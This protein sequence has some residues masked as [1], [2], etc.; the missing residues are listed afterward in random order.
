MNGFVSELLIYLGLFGGVAAASGRG[1]AS[2]A[3]AALAA[4][5]LAM[6]GALAVACFVKV[7][8]VVFLGSARSPEAEGSRA[9]CARALSARESPLSMLAPMAALATLCAFIGLAPSLVAPILD[10]VS[11]SWTFAAGGASV[12][13]SGVSSG[14]PSLL[15]LAPLGLVGAAS[16]ALVAATALVALLMARKARKAR[17]A[18][19]WDCGY[20]QPTA[21]MQYTASSF[22]RGIVGLFAWALHPRPEPERIKGA[23]PGR[24]SVHGEVEDAVLDRVLAPAFRRFSGLSIALRRFQQ[25]LTQHYVLYILVALIALLIPLLPFDKIIA[26]IIA[27]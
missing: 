5:C 3:L 19:T 4:P 15:G 7:C 16:A 23:Y 18:L 17:R 13:A 26:L 1:G 2:L 22:A 8:G 20:A 21:R 25:G 9:S 12:G 24:E 11:G 10:S 27:N 14:V 6:I